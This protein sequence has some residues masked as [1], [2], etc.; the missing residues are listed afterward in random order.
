MQFRRRVG[1]A[2]SV[3][4]NSAQRA[5]DSCA[6]LLMRPRR[7]LRIVD[8]ALALSARRN[9]GCLQR[10][11]PL[12]AS[13]TP[14]AFPSPR[15][16]TWRLRRPKTH[17]FLG[18]L[19]GR[20]PLGGAAL[21]RR[22]VVRSARPRQRAGARMEASLASQRGARS[23][24]TAYRNLT[25][26]RA[27]RMPCRKDVR[28]RRGSK[29]AC[30]GALRSRRRAKWPP[31]WRVRVMPAAHMACR[32]TQPCTI[33]SRAIAYSRRLTRCGTSRDRRHSR[34]RSTEDLVQG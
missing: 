18:A 28:S 31:P 8:W 14:A 17:G 29:R 26:R 25:G 16:N 19:E 15:A 34:G 10:L 11:C 30:I 2:P 21:T 4:P 13:P 27:G 3:T 20:Q 5:K 7:R 24:A 6:L 32:G 12:K 9:G 1:R 22:E 23:P 33:R